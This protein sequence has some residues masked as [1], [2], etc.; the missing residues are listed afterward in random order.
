MYLLIGFVRFFANITDD[1]DDYDDANKYNKKFHFYHTPLFHYK[2]YN[3]AL[4]KK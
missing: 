4:I 2:D 3:I 1:A